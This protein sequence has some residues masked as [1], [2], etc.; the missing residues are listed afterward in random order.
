VSH[1]ASSEILQDV[2]EVMLNVPVEFK[3]AA[4]ETEVADRFR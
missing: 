2:L 3:A 1:V 4:I